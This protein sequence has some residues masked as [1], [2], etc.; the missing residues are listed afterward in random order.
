MST[1]QKTAQNPAS[2]PTTALLLGTWLLAGTLDILAACINFLIHGGKD[3]SRIFRYIASGVF[4]P[5]AL[6]GGFGFVALGAVFHYLVALIWTAL[7]FLLYPRLKMKGANSYIVG[8]LYGAIV[9]C[10]MNLIVVPLSRTPELHS[11]LA[12]KAVAMGILMACIG[13]PISLMYHRRK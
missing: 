1:D 11:T 8:I 5:T 4:G 2:R 6:D 7:F 12:Q 9:W 10:G 3:I 13:L